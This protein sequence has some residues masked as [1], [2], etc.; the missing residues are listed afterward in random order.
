MSARTVAPALVVVRKRAWPPCSG[1]WGHALA[2]EGG[3]GH[4]TWPPSQP[5]GHVVKQNN[6]KDPQQG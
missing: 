5:R 6:I 3:D 4:P 2:V 1:C